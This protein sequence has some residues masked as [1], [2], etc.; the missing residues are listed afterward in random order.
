MLRGFAMMLGGGIEMFGCF[1]VVMMNFVLI[2]HGSL[3]VDYEARS[4]TGV[5]LFTIVKCSVTC[6]T[7]AA[8]SGE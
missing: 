6:V 8:E 7:L 3:R 1:V 2:A 4:T 5:S